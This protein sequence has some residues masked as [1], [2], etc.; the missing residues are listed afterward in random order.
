MKPCFEWNG[1]TIS[2]IIYMKPRLTASPF[3]INNLFKEIVAMKVV[4]LD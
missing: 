3:L 4:I 2:H 1:P